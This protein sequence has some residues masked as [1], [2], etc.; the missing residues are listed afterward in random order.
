[1]TRTWSYLNYV[2]Q[3]PELLGTAFES[4]LQLAERTQFILQG[5]DDGV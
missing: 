5:S 4:Q 2:N 1:M 3:A